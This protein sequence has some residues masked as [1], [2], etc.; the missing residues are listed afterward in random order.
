MDEGERN[1]HDEGRHEVDAIDAEGQEMS[2]R[3]KKMERRSLARLKVRIGVVAGWGTGRWTAGSTGRLIIG[4]F[5]SMGM[6]A[7]GVDPESG[8]VDRGQG[9]GP[10]PGPGPGPGLLLALSRKSDDRGS[11]AAKKKKTIRK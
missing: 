11:L 10:G 7:E 5:R 1:D 9:L 2:M 4:M 3:M 8:R 6:Y